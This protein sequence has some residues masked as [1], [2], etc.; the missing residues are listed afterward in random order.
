MYV[1]NRARSILLCSESLFDVLSSLLCM[2]EISISF[3][4]VKFEVRNEKTF[5]DILNFCDWIDDCPLFKQITYWG[6]YEIIVYM[7]ILKHY[8]YR[9][10]LV[11]EF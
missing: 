4:T 5:L 1:L 11:K 10:L 9:K 7:L 8:V 2:H 6:I 3:D